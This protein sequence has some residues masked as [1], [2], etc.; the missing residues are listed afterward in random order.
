MDGIRD[1]LVTLRG[2]IATYPLGSVVVV[3]VVLGLYLWDVWRRPD[4]ACT[5]CE[6]KGRVLADS[7]FLRRLTGGSCLFCQ[8]NPWRMRRVARWLGWTYNSRVG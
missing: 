2:V 7:F 5:W 4:K 6:G 1:L 8:D 3:A